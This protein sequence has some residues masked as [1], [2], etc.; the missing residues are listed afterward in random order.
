MLIIVGHLSA[1]S[2]RHINRTCLTLDVVNEPWGIPI[3]FSYI[4]DFIFLQ[5]GK[6][7]AEVKLTGI[8]SL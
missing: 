4:Y 1:K 6:I 7:E 5:D 3:I 8:L 2:L